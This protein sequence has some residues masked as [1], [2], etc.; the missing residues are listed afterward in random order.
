MKPI[1]V[2]IHAAYLPRLQSRIDLYLTK[3]EESGLL[4]RVS[5]I[6]ISTV[7]SPFDIQIS[8]HMQN[9]VK[10]VHVS[11][12]LKDFELPTLKLLYSY[13]KMYPEHQVL[14]LHTKGVG[15]DIN[16]C[17]EDWVH[18]MLYF[19]IERHEDAFRLLD[20]HGT[21]GVDLLQKPTL[22]YSGNFWWANAAHICTLPD[23]IA[24]QSYPNP[25]NSPRHNQEFWICF[26]GSHAHAVQWQSNID[27]YKRHLHLYPR[28]MY[29]S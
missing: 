26:G 7:G 14:Y 27:C 24:F 15:K 29:T 5:C 3:L 11:P 6:Y 13:Y 1:A 18:Y 21:T 17:I 16:P 20:S 9:K 12:H 22:H 23:P 28:Q 4:A 2:F 25:L 19:L 10:V 8:A